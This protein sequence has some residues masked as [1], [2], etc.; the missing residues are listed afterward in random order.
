MDRNVSFAWYKST[1]EVPIPEENLIGILEPDEILPAADLERTVNENLDHPIGT[2]PFNELCAGKRKILVL[3]S[4]LSRPM[5]TDRVLPIV[6]RRI[7]QAAPEAEVRILVAQ[8]THRALNREEKLRLVG[9]DVLDRY[10]VLDHAYDDPEQLI[11]LEGERADFPIYV[12]RLLRECD[13]RIGIGAV[14]PHPIFGWSGGC[15]IIIPGVSGRE[16]T[17]ISH[18]NSTPFRGI[19]IMGRVENPVR[20]EV[21][22]VVEKEK[23]IDFILNAVLTE[24]SRVHD[25]RCGHF[26][27]AHRAAVEI[28]GRYY[29]KDAEPADAIVV[30]CGKWGADLWVGS[31]SIY[32]A[33]FF[34][35]KGGTIVALEACP[36]GVAP[37]HPEVLTYGYRPYPVVKRMVDSGILA[38]DLT[39]AAH[40]VHVGRV[41]AE[42]QADC[43]LLSDGIAREDAEKLG[44]GYLDSIGEILPYIF[45]KHGKNA[46]I[47]AIPGFASTNVISKHP[48]P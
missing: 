6:L 39:T 32:S 31:M 8:G 13:L 30:G 42:R 17:G 2:P 27:R 46:R 47:L 22:R 48:A 3:I 5:E 15:K 14:K 26:I 4:D 36:E 19:D 34:V 20:G 25:V 24:D 21:E 40:L 9:K 1:R 38:D 44:F 37:M 23:L 10:P 16:T 43:V 29:Y 18:W 35:K 33:E 7:E 28:A 12:N 45:K 11:R 41:I